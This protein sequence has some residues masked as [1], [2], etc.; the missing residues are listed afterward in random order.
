MSTTAWTPARIHLTPQGYCFTWI[1]GSFS[2]LETDDE[3]LFL[4]DRETAEDDAYGL[5]L[6]EVELTGARPYGDELL[7]SERQ[8]V[9]RVHLTPECYECAAECDALTLV[10]LTSANAPDDERAIEPACPQHAGPQGI[11]LDDLTLALGADV[12]WSRTNMAQSW[13]VRQDANEVLLQASLE[14]QASAVLALLDDADALTQWKIRVMTS[15][16]ALVAALDDLRAVAVDDLRARSEQVRDLFSLVDPGT[17]TKVRDLL[18]S[19]GDAGSRA[20][21]LASSL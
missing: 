19:A 6:L 11:S 5:A 10:E 9:T 3:A 7:A 12:A 20:A 21:F 13:Q 15:N 1:H 4:A 16:E 17:R 18:V 8:R 14:A 2:A